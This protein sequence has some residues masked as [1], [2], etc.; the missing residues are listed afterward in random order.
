MARMVTCLCVMMALLPGAVRGAQAK[1]KESERKVPGVAYVRPHRVRYRRNQAG[2]IAVAVA[3]PL[4]KP[5]AGRLLCEVIKEL[6]DRRVL[7]DKPVQVAA[8][9]E[10]VVKIP[11]TNDGTEF[12]REVRAT[13]YGAKG[14]VLD[15]K[16]EYFS[17][18]DNIFKVYVGDTGYARRQ[19]PGPMCHFPI[20]WTPEVERTWREKHPYTYCNLW[21]RFSWAPGEQMDLTPDTELWWSGQSIYRGSKTALRGQ[22]KAL[23]DRGVG[24]LSYVNQGASGTAGYEVYRQHP[25]WFGTPGQ[26]DT[27]LL[28]TWDTKTYREAKGTWFAVWA[29]WTVPEARQYAIN[30]LIGT[31]KMFGWDGFRW[32]C[33]Q[34][35]A[36]T[37]EQNAQYLKEMKTK[38]RAV[39]P[40]TLF[41]YNVGMGAYGIQTNTDAKA[42]AAKP[43]PAF[44]ELCEGGGLIMNE[45]T[46]AAYGKTHHLHKWEDFAQYLANTQEIVKRLGGY[47]NPFVLRR[48]GAK[49]DIDKRYETVLQLAAGSHPYGIFYYHAFVTRYSALLWG[50]HV[51]KMREPEKSVRVTAKADL[52]WRHQATTRTLSDDHVQYILHLVNPPY[53][54][55]IEE[56]PKQIVR[57]PVTRVRITATPPGRL[58]CKQAWVLSPDD[59][60]WAHRLTPSSRGG[61]VSVTVPVPVTY[62][63]I[64]VL[65]FGQ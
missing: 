18:A 36:P 40:D 24:V 7:A 22:I 17:V 3:N 63:S 54:E 52:W 45:S 57:P 39:F 6:D 9:G 11:Y 64:V 5:L 14:K 21:E 47:F 49:Y 62:W 23:Q 30:E 20:S 19:A 51:W 15:T 29:N 10:A 48:G 59:K 34:F 43:D 31:K 38:V 41:G 46:Y 28:A 33:G 25:E 27:Q 35:E 8:H 12:G 53:S 60:P 58:R 16:S 1:K 42:Y 37:H 13:L 32:D 55:G 2:T 4:G 26:F 56:N 50:D 44:A 61:R 65:D